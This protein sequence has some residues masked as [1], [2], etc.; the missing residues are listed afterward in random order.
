M[1]Y[2]YR[3]HLCF[4]LLI[5]VQIMA[6]AQ[7]YNSI[8]ISVDD[9]PAVSKDISIERYELITAK[10]LETFDHYKI[11]AIGFV[12][13]IKLV[14]A[15][16][17]ESRSEALLRA[18]VEHGMELGNHTYSH[19]DY[20]KN[21]IEEFEADLARGDHFTKTL[22]DANTKRIKYF[23]HPYLHT[24]NSK[25][26]KDQLVEVL[27]KLNY[28]EAPVTV[29]NS[30]WI[31]ARAYDISL[32]QRDS[33][34]ASRMGRDYVAYMVEKVKYFETQSVG[35]FGRNIAQ[36]LLIHANTINADFLPTLL[37]E[38]VKNGYRFTSMTE[39]LKDNAYLTPNE[40]SGS[41]GISWIHRWAITQGKPKSFFAGEPKTPDYILKYAGIP[42][43]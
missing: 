13:E 39:T 24:G 16:R 6:T 12:N 26:K 8:C 23:R 3:S 21:G 31:F 27:S 14:E 43:E 20:H 40:Y 33:T 41:P 1:N 37:D 18:W 32:E 30:D 25:L 36:I 38:L 22:F 5:A 28:I 11:P 2:F 15:S 34:I 35:I 29:D 9:L 7:S 10:L 17:P 19:M 4:V 42:E